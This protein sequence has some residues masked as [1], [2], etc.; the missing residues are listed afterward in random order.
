[1]RN[2]LVLA[3]RIVVL[4]ALV[5]PASAQL[6]ERPGTSTEGW[7]DR[8][9]KDL[10]GL[11]IK[12]RRIRIRSSFDAREPGTS[13]W[14]I[15]RDPWLA[16]QRGR[17]LFQRQWRVR[18]GATGHGGDF[19]GGPLGDERTKMLPLADVTSCA[20]CHTNVPREPGPGV[21]IPKN[22]GR[23]R[24]TLSA[25][26][27]GAI[28]MIGLQTRMKLMGQ[29]DTD[30]DGWIS[31]KEMTGAELVVE[32]APGE[33]PLSFGKN[34]DADHDGH[35]DLNTVLRLWYVDSD[36]HMLPDAESLDDPE[37]A[38]YNFTMQIFGWGHREGAVSSTVRGFARNAMHTH[39]GLDAHDGVAADDPDRDGVASISV[40][41]A[42][43]FSVEPSPDAGVTRTILGI[44]ADDPDGDGVLEEFSQGEMDLLEF[45]LLHAAIPAQRPPTERTSRGR[46]LMDS[47]GCTTCHVP[48][49]RIEPANPTSTDVYGRF[50]GDRR[51]FELRAAWNE[52][53]GRLEAQVKDLSQIEDGLRVPRRGAATFTG[54]YSDFRHHEMGDGFAEL[55]FD[56]SIQRHFRTPPLWGVGHGAPY[57]HDGAS[58]DLD[59]V[60][61]RHGGEAAAAAEAY[62]KASEADREALVTFLNSL[63][64][65]QTEELP[66]DVDG[67]GEIE[68]DGFQVA[69][70]DVGAERFNPE[71]LFNTPVEIE[72]PVL[73]PDGETVR[74]MA[75]VNRTAAYGEDLPAATDIDEDGFPDVIDPCPE[76]T[77]YLDGCRN[78]PVLATVVASEDFS[79]GPSGWSRVTNPAFP[80]AGFK[81]E[82]GALQVQLTAPGQ[83][84]GFVSPA[85][86]VAVPKGTLLRVSWTVAAE[87]DA[88]GKWPSFRLMI[89]RDAFART[90]LLQIDA[91][92]DALES[93]NPWGRQYQQYLLAEADVQEWTFGFDLLGLGSQEG[94][95]IR[96][97]NLKVENLGWLDDL[98]R[99]NSTMHLEFA[100][101][102]HGWQPASDVA[103]RPAE[104][105]AAADGLVLQQP[106]SSGDVYGSW[107]SPLLEPSAVP[108]RPLWAVG[109]RIERFADGLAPALRLRI[110]EKDNRA[111]NCSIWR[112]APPGRISPTAFL[113]LSDEMEAEELTI[114]FDLMG[115]DGQADPN[116]GARLEAISLETYRAATSR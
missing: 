11:S 108:D 9:A 6:S 80:A 38:G 110:T 23:G 69:G 32:P 75:A 77:G 67:D 70:R 91:Q 89:H 95:T 42:R 56:G 59:A 81:D 68:E 116:G 1:M 48:D 57:G 58:L 35:P 102:T 84:G 13:G 62:A 8:R 106:G 112:S 25:F 36:G 74:S 107:T 53:A 82:F 20:A 2:R 72:G 47:F 88:A 73:N 15:R 104:A 101:Q 51:L 78:E 5:G 100:G 30:R 21:T 26:G 71:W 115:F 65:Y 12:S 96:V 18:D 90:D 45:Y 16:F 44:S 50:E 61:R 60:I 49:W 10:S 83:Y 33:S 103:F 22:S 109:A 66:F 76:V 64:L 28:E 86:T 39:I 37:V 4:L 29:A 97:Q 113:T 17:D 34:E 105:A 19:I 94:A 87:E 54:V 114:T 46:V 63:V 92:P 99:S 98:Y 55:N 7:S 85:R 24:Q 41:G 43:Q 3:F 40:N 111:T 52:A 93:P 14:F 31:L 27:A 79:G